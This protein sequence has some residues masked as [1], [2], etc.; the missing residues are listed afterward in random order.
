M[1]KE[2]PAAPQSNTP[3]KQPKP[4]LFRLISPENLPTIGLI[5]VG[6]WGILVAIGTLNHMRESSERQLRAY[7]LV[8]NCSVFNVAKPVQVFRGQVFQH[9]EAEITNLAC[10]PGVRVFIKNTG[11]TPAYEV[12]HVGHI[13]FREHPLKAPLPALQQSTAPPASVL[14]PGVLSS[15][16]L[17][18][19]N[20]LAPQETAQLRDGTGAIY[21]YG[22]ISYR[23]AFKR[24]QWTEYRLFHNMFSGAVGVS[25][26]LTFAEGGN[27]AT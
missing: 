12:C 20:P 7:V 5:V 16:L 8:D 11:Q 21:V 15:K 26:D 18:I 24:E 13:A 17:F 19:P 23:D 3:D 14:G 2:P 9:S 6:I 27:D 4:Y 10:G 25:T 1:T 22:R